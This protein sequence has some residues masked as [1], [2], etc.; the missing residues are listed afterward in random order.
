MNRKSVS[1][2][3]AFCL[4]SVLAFSSSVSAEERAIPAD[5]SYAVE[6]ELSL[7]EYFTYSW[8]SDMQLT[9]TVTDPTGTEVP[10]ETAATSGSG[11]IPSYTPG[12]YTMTWFN[13]G[14]SLAHLSFDLSGSFE[15]AEAALSFVLWALIIAAIVIVAI[16]VIVVI[17][18]VGRKKSS[19]QPSMMPPQ[20][21]TQALTTGQCPTCGSQIDL[22]ASFCS[23][24]GTRYR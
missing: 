1:A 9:F 23:K 18:V 17:V 22:N 16:V 15:E 6:V 13:Y 21:A 3:A 19:T 24:C 2:L 12:T 10:Y 4:V 5:D 11:I 8:S 20:V 7:L 14:S